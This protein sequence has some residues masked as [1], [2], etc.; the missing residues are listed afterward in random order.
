MLQDSNY[1]LEI[2]KLYRQN[3]C[4]EIKKKFEELS[5]VGIIKHSSSFDLL[6]PKTSPDKIFKWW[7]SKKVQASRKNFLEDYCNDKRDKNNSFIKISDNY[8]NLAN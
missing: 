6:S 3:I 8:N 7:K 4:K 2:Q 5:K 1:T